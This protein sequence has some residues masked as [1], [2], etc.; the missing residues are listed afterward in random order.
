LLGQRFRFVLA[1]GESLGVSNTEHARRHARRNVRTTAAGSP[2]GRE[3]VVIML[4]AEDVLELLFA[5]F[6][7][8]VGI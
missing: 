8:I 3:L 5:G 4:V 6:L 7:L 1:D 2:A